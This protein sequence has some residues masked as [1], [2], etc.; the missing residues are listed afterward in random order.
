MITRVLYDEEREIYDSVI[1]HPVQTWAWG[2][3]LK[4]QGHTVFRLGVFDN[5]TLVSAYSINFHRLPRLPYSIGVVQRGPGIDQD[6]LVNIAKI[7]QDQKAIFVKLEPNTIEKIYQDTQ[8]FKTISHPPEY[9]NLF[10]SP[11]A[12]FLPHSHIIDLSKST[13]SLLSDMH[14]KTRY[15]IKIA[16]RHQVEVVEDNTERGFNSYINLLFETT[17]RQGFYLHSPKYHQDLWETLKNTGM[18]HI[19][20][21]RWQGQLLTAMMFFKVGNYF[22]YPYGASSDQNRQVMASTLTM[23]EAIKLGKSLGCTTFDMWGSLPPDAKPTDRGFG[24]HRFKEGFGGQLVQFTGSYDYVLEHKLY[25]FY[26][27]VD[28]YRWKLLRLKANLFRF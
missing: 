14:A 21:A 19:L 17:R 13:D 15:N 23:W 10:V 3:F 27:T 11:K 25:K 26:N 28:K 4:S 12:G 1:I 6:L 8:T 7:G 2:D 24:F 5:N 20:L 9:A 22:Y 16:N 18:I